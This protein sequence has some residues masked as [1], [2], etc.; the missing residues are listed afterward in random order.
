MIKVFH[1]ISHFDLGGAEKI[2]LNISKSN[3][4][5]FEYHILEVKKS[6]NKEYSDTFIKDAKEA[7][8]VIH[9]SKISNTKLSIII[10]PIRFIKIFIKNKPDVIHTHTE[11]PDTC[12]Y[13][14]FHIFKHLKCKTK[15]VRT[16]HNN[17]LWN[18][19]KALGRI[20]ENFYKKNATNITISKSVQE[21]YYKNY[22]QLYPIIYNGVA[23]PHHKKKFSGIV[24]NK[25]NIVFAGRLEYQK[26][27][28]V[29][30]DV[31][32][33]LKD[34]N[35]FFF[36]IIGEGSQKNLIIENLSN[37]NNCKYYNVI[38][39]FADYLESFD[40][41]FMPSL[42][43]G[44]ALT[45]IEA[46]LA[47][48]PIIVNACPGIEEIIPDNWPLKVN[49]NNIDDFISLFKSLS[50]FK[51]QTLQDIAFDYASKKFSIRTM[52]NMYEKIYAK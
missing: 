5:D 28:K 8:I 7:N 44:L 35:R 50:N 29:L 48:T 14:F 46:C 41:L 33:Q 30:I 36:H 23:L 13:I 6:K 51:Y 34:D 11:V 22:S 40:Y 12:I 32:I 16:I 21:S 4:T 19:W 27:I 2:A 37:V 39:S 20:I 15:I 18:Q 47:K 38:Y 9:K 43:E 24:P 26:G 49:N 25:I 3:N 31:I 52:Q 10:F 1:I 42:F 45:P 17:Q